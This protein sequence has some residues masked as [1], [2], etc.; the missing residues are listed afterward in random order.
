MVNKFRGGKYTKKIEPEQNNTVNVGG[1]AATMCLRTV[2]GFAA[3]GGGMVVGY[4]KM[5]GISHTGPSHDT[6]PDIDI[7]GYNLQRRR[8]YISVTRGVNPWV[9]R[10]LCDGER[11]AINVRQGT[12]RARR[13]TPYRRGIS[14]FN[15][16]LR[17]PFTSFTPFT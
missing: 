4:R 2:G 3:G 13:D 7:S 1:S 10:R 14:C 5:M 17:P 11:R 12:E 9:R 15:N 8:R 16:S 6:I